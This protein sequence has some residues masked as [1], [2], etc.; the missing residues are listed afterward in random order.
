MKKHIVGITVILLLGQASLIFGETTVR[1]KPKKLPVSVKNA[2]YKRELGPQA[3]VD[4]NYRTW[5]ASVM[6]LDDGNYHAY[7]ARWESTRGFSSW[8]RYSEIAHAVSDKPEGPFISTGTVISNR[9]WEG[10]DVANAHNPYVCVVDGEIN[11][12]YIANNLKES[13]PDLE[14]EIPLDEKWLNQK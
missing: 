3:L 8:L 14:D 6:K 1:I 10:W 12:Y 13:G 5:G 2:Y 11:L 7:Y 9:N 4:P